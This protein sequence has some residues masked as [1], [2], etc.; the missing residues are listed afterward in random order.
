MEDPWES[1]EESEGGN[2]QG[3]KRENVL[4]IDHGMKEFEHG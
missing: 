1:E 4:G 2:G 3:A